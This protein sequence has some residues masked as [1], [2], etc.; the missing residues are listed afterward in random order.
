MRGVELE[1]FP[2]GACFL[3]VAESVEIVACLRDDQK[4]AT[5]VRELPALFAQQLTSE[6]RFSCAVATLA[7]CLALPLTDQALAFEMLRIIFAAER[8]ERVHDINE[9]FVLVD[10]S[11][12]IVTESL[13]VLARWV[14]ELKTCF[15]SWSE[16]L[17]RVELVG[18]LTIIEFR[19]HVTLAIIVA[20]FGNRSHA[21]N[22]FTRTRIANDV[23]HSAEL[24]STVGV[25][26]QCEIQ[27]HAT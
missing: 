21:E 15:G 19:V 12:K 25:I 27:Q 22:S 6:F 7:L 4:S 10:C 2:A 1:S 17:L 16:H 24:P 18:V 20:R 14:H 8:V 11:T 26:C 9:R 13:D 23:C 5:T 3:L